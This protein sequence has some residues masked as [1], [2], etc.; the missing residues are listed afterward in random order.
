MSR[1]LIG[2][3]E[4]PSP[5]TSV[6]TPIITLLI[7]RGSMRTFCSDCPSMSMKPGATTS[8]RASIVRF[9]RA[10]GA[11][12]EPD[13]HDAVARRLRPR[14]RPRARPVHDAPPD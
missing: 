1:S 2:A 6:V 10:Q 7:A 3:M 14:G 12:R 13:A 9:A 11:T 5:V 4:P 8:P